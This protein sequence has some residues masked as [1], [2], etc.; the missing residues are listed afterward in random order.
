MK[1][2]KNFRQK[3]CNRDSVGLLTATMLGLPLLLVGSMIWVGCAT[4]SVTL[5]PIKQ[6]DI[7]FLKK[8]ESFTAPDEGAF[9]SSFY[10]GEVM[11]AKVDHE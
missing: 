2:R 3:L 4:K 7:V 8:A 10:L 1:K 9:V 11:K 6:T 5:Y